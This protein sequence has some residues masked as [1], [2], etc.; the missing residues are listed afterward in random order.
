MLKIE[1]RCLE[2]FN[3]LQNINPMTSLFLYFSSHFN[4]KKMKAIDMSKFKSTVYLSFE[5]ANVRKKFHIYTNANKKVAF[6]ENLNLNQVVFLSKSKVDFQ[7]HS[8]EKKKE[9]RSVSNEKELLKAILEYLDNS[10]LVISLKKDIVITKDIPSIFKDIPCIAND[11]MIFSKKEHPVTH[12]DIFTQCV[13]GIIDISE[14]QDFY[15]LE[16][17]ESG[18]YVVSIKNNFK[19]FV[20][21]ALSLENF[22]GSLYILGNHHKLE[23][24]TIFSNNNGVGLISSLH[25]YSN[26][27]IRDL[28]L[29]QLTFEEALWN[30]GFVGY[31][32]V[33]QNKYCSPIGKVCLENCVLSDSVFLGKTCSP[34][35]GKTDEGFYLRNSKYQNI[36]TKTKTLKIDS[37]DLVYLPNSF[38]NT[39]LSLRLEKNGL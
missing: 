38:D 14:V 19:N 21:K 36:Q 18:N 30:G 22:T 34:F 23:N 10:L 2:D 33:I 31:R 5:E 16:C 1:I 9:V 7:Y 35:M 27:F 28:S 37:S 15:S 32:N 11:H 29:S 17:L 25:P 13:D 6:F 24:G 26:I 20:I 8:Y 3:A 39:F 12:P 4:L